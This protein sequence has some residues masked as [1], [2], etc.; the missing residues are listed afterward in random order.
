M[1]VNQH[2]IDETLG[3][4]RGGDAGQHLDV[5]EFVGDVLRA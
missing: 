1:A 3:E 4:W 5:G 2:Q